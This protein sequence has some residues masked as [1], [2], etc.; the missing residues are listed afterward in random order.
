M[1]GGV[2][3]TIASMSVRSTVRR[4]SQPQ[5]QPSCSIRPLGGECSV[6][7]TSTSSSSGDAT[8]IGARRR[9]CSPAPMNATRIVSAPA[10]CSRTPPASDFVIEEPK[11]AELFGAPEAGGVEHIRI[12]HAT[13]DL[14]KIELAIVGPRRHQHQSVG[15]ADSLGRII[16]EAELGVC[17]NLV[18]V[19]A[20][21]VRI[22]LR[23][24][25]HE[26]ADHLQGGG[27]A[28]CTGIGLVSEDQ[29]RHA[30]VR[31]IWDRLRELANDE[32]VLPLI[33]G[34]G[35]V[36]QRRAEIEAAAEVSA[37]L[38]VGVCGG[39]GNDA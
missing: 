15:A 20:R 26:I 9:V 24:M 1:C 23:A 30:S 39:R 17:H 37:R 31:E 14:Y 33:G 28:Q 25:L 7:T 13:L 35:A 16:E 10:L 18:A 34:P 12:C 3:T 32:T 36:Q 38:P 8:T 2:Q 22:H 21:I 4:Q 29:H 11:A 27:A 19:G 6:P 5:A